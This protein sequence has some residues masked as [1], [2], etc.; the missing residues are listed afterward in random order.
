MNANFILRKLN[1]CIQ[2]KEY[3]NKYEKKNFS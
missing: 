2:K 3:I 1:Y